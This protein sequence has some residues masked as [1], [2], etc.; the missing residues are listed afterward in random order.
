VSDIYPFFLVPGSAMDCPVA[1]A[2][3]ATVVFLDLLPILLDSVVLEK[4]CTEVK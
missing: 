4:S 2:A 1:G 3:G